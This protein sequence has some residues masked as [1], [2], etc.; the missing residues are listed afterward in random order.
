MTI[1]V[2][3]ESMRNDIK[4]VGRDVYVPYV[5]AIKNIDIN[6][7]NLTTTGLGTFKQLVT[8]GSL[9]AALG[10]L[11]VNQYSNTLV[12]SANNDI[13][14][15]NLINPTFTIGAYTGVKNIGLKVASGS[16]WFDGTT[17]ITPTSG[18]GTRLMWIPDKGAF[19]AGTVAG[20]QWDDASIGVGS[21]GFGTSN[22]GSGANSLMSG[23][24]N[25]GSGLNVLGGG[26]TGNII[27]G[28]NAGQVGGDTNVIS[29]EDAFGGGGAGNTGS[30]LRAVVHCYH[31]ASTGTDSFIGGGNTNQA[32][33]T[34][35]GVLC[36]TLGQATGINSGILCGTSNIASSLNAASWGESCTAGLN[37]ADTAKNTTS[38]GYHNLADWLNAVATGCYTISSGWNGGT[39]GSYTKNL[40][41]SGLVWGQNDNQDTTSFL[42]GI[43]RNAELG[44]VV[45]G[46]AST[47][48][49]HRAQGTASMVFGQ[50][51]NSL[52]NP[53]CIGIGKGFTV[54]N[55]ETFF[56]SFSGLPALQVT[57]SRVED[58]ATYQ[59]VWDDEVVYTAGQIVKY[60][61]NT[62]LTRYYVCILQPPFLEDPTNILYW[63]VIIDGKIGINLPYV[64]AGYPAT[65]RP[66]AQWHIGASDGSVGT[67]PIKLTYGSLTP[68]GEAGAIEYNGTGYYG[69]VEAL[70]QANPV[71]RR[72]A[73]TEE[74][75]AGYQ[76][77]D[78]DLT[79]IAGLSSADGNIIVGSA[80]GWV[81]E[82]GAT[83]RTS[84]GLAIGTDVLAYRTF[85][86][87][88]NNDTGDFLAYN[89]TAVAVSGLT[90]TAGASISNANTGDQDLSGYALI[91]QTMYIGT[92]GVAINRGTGALAL[93]GVSIDGA[94]GSCSG[95][96]ATASAVTGLSVVAG[97][98]LTVTTGGTLV[99]AGY[100][101]TL[102]QSGTLGTAAY[103]A[104]GD[105]LAVAGTAAKATILATARTIAG[106]SF[107]GSANIDISY[108][109]LTNKPTLG[110]ASAQNVEAFVRG[111]FLT[112]KYY[113]TT[114]SSQGG[115][116]RIT[117]G[118]TATKIVSI[119]AMVD[120]NGSG[121]WICH[122]YTVTAGYE[123]N[124]QETSGYIY[125]TNKS[126]NSE[127]ILSKTCVVFI[128]YEP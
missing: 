95:N 128:T 117:H 15:A 106:T 30:G 6:S 98:T 119:V 75:T 65:T 17:G 99:L 12:A 26:G 77:L 116:V 120:Y 32:T 42:G 54:N 71:R 52:T 21:A 27:S 38:F 82:S 108:A 97:Q 41:Q 22:I 85:G 86:S 48:Y 1:Y 16:V 124:V 88:A 92:T 96:A 113:V 59:G 69:T 79:A 67:T 87:A 46:Y 45:L 84:L 68:I 70:P 10:T 8:T 123:F 111:N 127:N 29:G 112:A 93:A 2:I 33:T 91:G 109:N 37:G 66:T 28:A 61:T 9:S 103:A 3:P 4:R 107:D 50:D 55:K 47:G 83:A 58:E 5:G 18:A 125:I 25:T 23:T 13:L 7:R 62:T 121:G 110:T 76:P 73:F 72:F 39:G 81:A 114:N 94:S 64:V 24:L 51:V 104:T 89:G 31:N 80:T 100:S 78:D 35:S 20:T 60:V 44:V 102:A 105:F 11:T 118:L 53:N 14:I 56:V 74:V 63:R 34:N 122:S 115:N 19:R 90:I 101:L 49:T 57:N 126:G 43:T 36:G 40:A